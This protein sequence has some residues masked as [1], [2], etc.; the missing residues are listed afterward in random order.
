M[1]LATKTRGKIEDVQAQIAQ[2][3]K[4]VEALT[5]DQITPAVT[6]FA[7]RAGNAV[8]SAT[9]AVRNQT[10]VVSGQVKEWPLAAIL[11]AAAVG[12]LIARIIR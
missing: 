11:G 3:R 1:A 9:G 12:W 2:L 8:T 4:Q 10:Q 6:D 5:Q 7:S